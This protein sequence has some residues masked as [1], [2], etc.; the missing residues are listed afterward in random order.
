[1]QHIAVLSNYI[2]MISLIIKDLNPLNQIFYDNNLQLL[3]N[4]LLDNLTT[5]LVN[6]VN[7]IIVAGTITPIIKA[8]LLFM[9]MAIKFL[10]F[11]LNVPTVVLLMLSYLCLSFLFNLFQFSIFSQVIN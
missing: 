4:K 1:M 3:Y 6:A 9:V 11:G 10:L 8:E 7:V 2:D 5:Y